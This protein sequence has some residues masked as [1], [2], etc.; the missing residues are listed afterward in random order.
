MIH[1]WECY[2][3]LRMLFPPIR[4][5]GVCMDASKVFHVHHTDLHTVNMPKV[6]TEKGEHYQSSGHLIQTLVEGN[7]KGILRT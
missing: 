5:I 2:S 6:G 3:L 1:F 7:A 4:A